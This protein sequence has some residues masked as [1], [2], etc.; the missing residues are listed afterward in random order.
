MIYSTFRID[1]LNFDLCDLCDFYDWFEWVWWWSELGFFGW[2][3]AVQRNR[4]TWGAKVRNAGL[5]LVYLMEKNVFR[6]KKKGD[7]A[8]NQ[9][10]Y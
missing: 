5:F 4:S 7:Y 1:C 2:G 6:L 10:K 3:R 9:T 8:E